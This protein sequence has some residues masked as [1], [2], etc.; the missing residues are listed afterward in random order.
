MTPRPGNPAT[1]TESP[2]GF[3]YRP[4]MGLGVTFMPQVRA[5]PGSHRPRVGDGGGFQRRLG[6]AR[7]FGCLMPEVRVGEQAGSA[8]GVVD[9]RDLEEPV[10]LEL[11]AEQ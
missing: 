10:G 1:A 4:A 2:S 8:L 7:R 11:G 3:P 9:D 6:Q 5:S